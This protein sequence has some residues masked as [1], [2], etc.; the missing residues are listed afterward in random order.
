MKRVRYL[1]RLVF[2]AMAA[3]A[4][5]GCSPVAGV[6]TRQETPTLSPAQQ[7]LTPCAYTWATQSLPEVTRQ[8]Q[9]ALEAAGLSQATGR[10]EAFGEN[11]I[12]TSGAVRSFGTMETDFRIQLP[13]TDLADRQALGDLLEKV[14]VV[15]DQ[16]PPG[17]V[18]GPQTGYIGVEFSAGQDTL[19]LWF[20]AD[21]GQSARGQGLHGAELVAALTNH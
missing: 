15:L 17:K 14:M 6:E 8:V 21:A 13:V 9:A 5:A 2:L 12:E 20:K 4:L 7:E 10:A 3:L 16:F 1:N 11:C 19:N 18:P